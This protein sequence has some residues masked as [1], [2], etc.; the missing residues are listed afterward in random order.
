MRKVPRYDR[1]LLLTVRKA[2]PTSSTGTD[3]TPGSTDVL[4]VVLQLPGPCPVPELH[5]GVRQVPPVRPRHGWYQLY[6][7]LI[8]RRH[9]LGEVIPQDGAASPD[10][11]LVET[12]WLRVIGSLS[13]VPTT[14]SEINTDTVDLMA[15]LWE[16]RRVK[17]LNPKIQHYLMEGRS[18]MESLTVTALKGAETPPGKTWRG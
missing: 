18:L 4:V 1:V 11:P 13:L 5:H 9:L 12:L 17:I 6:S 3:S 14:P 2:A 8:E 16:K 15:K 7:C 10:H